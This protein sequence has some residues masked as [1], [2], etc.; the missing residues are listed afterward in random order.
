MLY[1]WIMRPRSLH[2]LDSEV[3]FKIFSILVVIVCLLFMSFKTVLIQY[4]FITFTYSLL[5]DLFIFF[6][7]WG[8]ALVFMYFDPP[9]D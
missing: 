3:S 2:F 4:V 1:A 6:A 8:T 9:A 7:C 5:L